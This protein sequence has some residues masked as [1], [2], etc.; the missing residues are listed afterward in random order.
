[1]QH[2]LILLAAACVAIAWHGLFLAPS[3]WLAA[4]LSGDR[5]EAGGA[6]GSGPDPEGDTGDGDPPAAGPPPD[7]EDPPDPAAE[8]AKWK[9]L[10]RKHEAQAKSNAEAARRLQLIEDEKKSEAQRLTE[11]AEAA[12]RDA[13][14]ARLEVLRRDVAAVKKLPPAMATRLAGATQEE[15]EA[16]ADQLLADLASAGSTQ[17]PGTGT[18]RPDTGQGRRRSDAKPSVTTGRDLYRDRHPTRT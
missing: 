17:P 15:L 1:M 12:E 18:A 11:R 7:V 16:D 4:R 10:A 6:G 3:R 13:A 5:G 14:A 9:S 2:L 8:V